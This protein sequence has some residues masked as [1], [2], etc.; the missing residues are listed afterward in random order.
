MVECGR[1]EGGRYLQMESQG[2][3]VDDFDDA[4]DGPQLNFCQ[5]CGI[6]VLC[7]V[8]TCYFLPMLSFIP[9]VVFGGVQLPSPWEKGYNK[10]APVA[11]VPAAEMPSGQWYWNLPLVTCILLFLPTGIVA[12]L[13]QLKMRTIRR[14]HMAPDCV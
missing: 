3:D 11:T 9:L 2:D 6:R 4:D 12:V 7:L 8:L 10:E 1:D 5:R 14:Q 13:Y